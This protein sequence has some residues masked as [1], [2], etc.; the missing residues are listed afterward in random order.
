M[1]KDYILAKLLSYVGYITPYTDARINAHYIEAGE[2]LKG[3]E[4]TQERQAEV[5]E[6]ID[7]FK[8]RASNLI[9]MKPQKP[10]IDNL[11]A[12]A[13]RVKAI[14]GE[15]PILFIDYLQLLQA[16]DKMKN[17]D[18]QTIIKD[19]TQKLKDYVI[20]YDTLAYTITAYNRDSTRTHGKATLESGRD[21]S[22]IE[23]SSDYILSINFTDYEQGN[24]D[25]DIE[26]LKQADTRKMTIKVLKNR[27]G[28][29]GDKINYD[30]IPKYNAYI[31]KEYFK[32]QQTQQQ[33]NYNKD[34][35]V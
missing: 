23:Y 16:T 33:Q 13:E 1:S 24:S 22:D 19:A 11:I 35:L 31:E 8:D 26:E 10:N 6:L 7:I 30:F 17:A 25:K 15:A 12:E 27:L 2:I 18:V 14:T 4:W 3:Y 29:T 34:N 9:V 32:Q 28:T 20:K 21:T 5:K